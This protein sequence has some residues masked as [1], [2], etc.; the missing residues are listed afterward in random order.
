MAPPGAGAELGRTAG[1]TTTPRLAGRCGQEV[2]TTS[3]L[4]RPCGPCRYKDAHRC[5]VTRPITARNGASQASRAASIADPSGSATP[6]P[7]PL[8]PASRWCPSPPL[9]TAQVV[10]GRAQERVQASRDQGP[11]L[12]QELPIVLP[13]EQTRIGR[14]SL[15]LEWHTPELLEQRR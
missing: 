5:R 1:S 8:R 3:P 2:A 11:S 4:P 6:P 13:S 12:A 10:S 7:R 14:D 15:G 9:R